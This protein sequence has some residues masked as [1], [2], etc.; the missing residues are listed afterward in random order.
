MG[1]CVS[2]DGT[3]FYKDVKTSWDGTTEEIKKTLVA[4][5]CIIVAFGKTQHLKKV[6]LCWNVTA[7]ELVMLRD[8]SLYEEVVLRL[9]HV[10]LSYGI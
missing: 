1:K 5:C 10:L 7:V 6:D 3:V 8:D 4:S 9:H 2:D